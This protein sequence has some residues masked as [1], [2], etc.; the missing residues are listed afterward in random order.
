[1]RRLAFAVTVFY[2][3]ALYAGPAPDGRSIVK[4][5]I[6]RDDG[7]DSIAQIDMLLTDRTGYTEARAM[8]AAAKDYGTLSKSLIRFTDPANIAGTSFLSWQVKDKS[9]EQFLFLPEL[10]RDRR[11]VSGQ[12]DKSFANTDYTY[13]DMEE[14][15][16]DDDAHRLLREEKVG[17]YDCWVVESTPRKPSSS[18][19][20]RWIVWIP[21]GI[22]VPLR[23]DYH[24]GV[25]RIATKVLTVRTL[26]KIDGFWT[27]TESEMKDLKRNHATRMRVRSIT[28]NS[29]LPDRMFT[30]EALGQPQ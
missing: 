14:R 23:I 30:R 5:V 15:K 4:K 20:K 1:M 26:E 25:P 29:G 11:I 22:F 2:G 28:Y 24:D 10:G 3:I 16:L 6:D 21:K 13:E 27:A 8:T 12:K 19:Y 7:K 17:A 9:D 18:K